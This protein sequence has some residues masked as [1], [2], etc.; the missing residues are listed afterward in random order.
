ML[1]A[2]L[3]RKRAVL[4]NQLGAA[5]GERTF[6]EWLGQSLAAVTPEPV[7]TPPPEA[8]VPEAATAAGPR[9]SPT[10]QKERLTRGWQEEDLRVLRERYAAGDHHA[11]IA[12][13]LGRTPNS[14]IGKI[15]RLGL[16]EAGER[17]RKRHADKERETLATA[18]VAA[19][20][21]NASY[22]HNAGDS[23]DGAHPGRVAGEEPVLPPRSVLAGAIPAPRSDDPS[24]EDPSP[25]DRN[26]TRPSRSPRLSRA[27]CGSRTSPASRTIQPGAGRSAR[28]AGPTASSTA[29]GLIGGRAAG[30]SRRSVS[31]RP[32]PQAEAA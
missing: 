5:L 16:R 12:E 13:A 9:I 18:I 14:V 21:R 11:D 22:D 30:C 28:P 7:E 26:P 6:R 24:P 25:E 23:R 15:H 20:A 8:P 32:P 31:T 17:R 1:T 10:T 27:A 3:V 19:S 29:C 4:C 2:D